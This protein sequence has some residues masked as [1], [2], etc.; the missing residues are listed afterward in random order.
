ML[1]FLGSPGSAFTGK[2]TEIS[3]AKPSSWFSSPDPA[4]CIG[5][6]AAS[7]LVATAISLWE[8]FKAAKCH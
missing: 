1:S 7:S 4:S 6:V 3:S 5:S 2:K 8:N